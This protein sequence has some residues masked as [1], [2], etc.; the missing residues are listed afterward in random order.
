MT[1]TDAQLKQDIER[2]LAWDSRI[3][4][5]EIGVRVD[6]GVV[7]FHGEVSNYPEMRVAAEIAE[8]VAGVRAVTNDLLVRILASQRHA[9]AEIAAAARSAHE[10]DVWVP[11]S[12]TCRVQEGRLTLE[13][14]VEWNYE[15]EA[16]ERAVHALRGVV[17]VVNEI[18]VR[19]GA[20][21]GLFKDKVRAA[22]ASLTE[23]PALRVRTSLGRVTLLG[24]ACSR[25]AVEHAVGVMWSVPGVTAVIDGV[26]R[27]P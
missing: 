10:W 26:A 16:G 6:N 18:R 20:G 2:E 5:A 3:H 9:D 17:S 8:R 15:R 27:R 4:A 24:E 21:G 14:E 22:L 11:P 1:K 12:V 13:G 7:S 19:P 25:Q 23:S